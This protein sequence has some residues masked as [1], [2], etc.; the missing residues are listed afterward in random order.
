MA[1]WLISELRPA[2]AR[3]GG[4]C[5]PCCPCWPRLSRFS[6]R[7]RRTRPQSPHTHTS[8]STAL[9]HGRRIGEAKVGPSG[10]PRIIFNIAVTPFPK[11]PQEASLFSPPDSP[12]AN[13]KGTRCPAS[14]ALYLL[15]YL[16]SASF[17]AAAPSAVAILHLTSSR[18]LLFFPLPAEPPGAVE[19]KIA[20]P[21]YFFLSREIDLARP[22]GTFCQHGVR[23]FRR[24]YSSFQG[25]WSRYV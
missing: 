15:F 5:G 8:C 21:S 20:T 24:R 12:T 25:E 9:Q 3:L 6:A 18:V 14:L 16:S 11:F 2:V 1:L 19:T 17:G 22:H 10:A 23:Q 13:Q 7:K 4:P